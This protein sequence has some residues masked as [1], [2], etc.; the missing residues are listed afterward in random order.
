VTGETSG[1][2]GT[3]GFVVHVPF[4]AWA[5]VV[6]V[7]L[8]MLAVDLFAHRRAHEVSLREAATWSAV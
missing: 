3:G 2:F 6:A 8:A 4:W 5:A 1:P 7:I